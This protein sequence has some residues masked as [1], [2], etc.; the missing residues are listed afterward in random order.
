MKLLELAHRRSSVAALLETL[1][2]RRRVA[3]LCALIG[4]RLGLDAH[5][6][7]RAAWL[8][9]VGMTAMTFVDRRGPLSDAERR[10][11]HGHTEIGRAL[12]DDSCTEL[13]TAAAVIAWTHHER[14]DGTGYPRGLAA[15]A[16]PLPGRIA[17]VADAFDAITTDRPHRGARSAATAAEV[18][19]AEQGLQF[20][21]AVLD[22]L[23]GA[24]DS[25]TRIL[26]RFPDDPAAASADEYVTV[27]VAAR[28]L[29]A[30]RSQLRR[31][32]DEGRIA[33]VRTSGG[34]RRFRLEDVRQLAE[35]LQALPRLR[36]IAPPDRPL[37]GVAAMLATFGPQIAGAA[38]SS[39]YTEEPHGWLTSE[40]ARPALHGWLDALREGCERGDFDAAIAVTETLLRE[41][42]AHG[43]T[44]LER[45][46]FLERFGQV[47]I[48]ALGR[49]GV[50][51]SER[52]GTRRLVVALQ[53]RALE[54]YD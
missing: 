30:S 19:R 35:H 41:A 40:H 23:L 6:L 7:G 51:Q 28:T 44:L 10:R 24:L 37:P 3:E 12:L 16:I 48:R 53:Q 25:A 22:V 38:S 14:Y 13:Y 15:D 54:S 20:D 34:H 18:L 5:A 45:H 11:L 33:A 32:S 50:E 27:Q 46:A 47:L 29:G 21:P 39:I 31:W 52:A 2:H 8:H 36:P 43:T 17:A 1:A 9:D 26:E 4:G 42:R 49:Q